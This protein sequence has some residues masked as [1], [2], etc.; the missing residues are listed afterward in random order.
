[1]FQERPG[2]AGPSVVRRHR[3]GI[4][5]VHGI[6][7]QKSAET[8]VGWGD[9]LVEVVTL[10]TKG[11][12]R[13]HLVNATTG[14]GPA[15]ATLKLVTGPRSEGW[16]LRECWWADTFPVPSY[17][18]LVSRSLKAIPWAIVLHVAGRYWQQSKKGFSLVASASAVAK[19]VLALPFGLLAMT[20]LALGLPFGA[21][22]IKKLRKALLA[23]QS[24]LTATV[25]DV[26]VFIDS[27][28]RAAI[29]RGRV[30]DELRRLDELCDET[31]VVAHSQ[32][33]AV[34]L[35]AL[36]G[37]AQDVTEEEP[38]W[39][40]RE[41]PM[42][43]ALVTFGA[44]INQLVGL[45][46]LREDFGRAMLALSSEVAAGITIAWML[47]DVFNGRVTVGEL[48]TTFGYTIMILALLGLLAWWCYSMFSS[49]WLKFLATLFLALLVTGLVG[50]L[51]VGAIVVS[52]VAPTL[53][54][55]SLVLMGLTFAMFLSEEM[56]RVA[57]NVV[58]RPPGLARWVDLWAS[59]DPVPNGATRVS[60][61]GDALVEH[62][63]WNR[64]SVVGDHTAYWGNADGFV[65]R[66]VR[67]CAR[68]A[69]SPWL[70][71]LPPDTKSI[72]DRAEW[73]VGFLRISRLLLA[74]WWALT[75]ALLLPRLG[76][77]DLWLPPVPLP[78]M[79]LRLFG[80]SDGVPDWLRLALLNAMVALVLLGASQ[81]IWSRWTN[82][83]QE[84][85][86]EGWW[87]EGRGGL[88][89]WARLVGLA[90]P[91]SLSVFVLRG[92]WMGAAVADSLGGDV[93]T[94]ISGVLLYGFYVV[95]VAAALALGLAL[96]MPPPALPFREEGGTS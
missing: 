59:H 74:L 62:P 43:T 38:L 14:N 49:N 25:G 7:R 24:L 2:S 92:F 89:G 41:G 33:A 17:R 58:R 75:T 30:A 8:L 18:E 73:R 80:W 31:V 36:G 94:V 88:G 82:S 34:A 69:R 32:G 66:V 78:D 42:P 12:T 60:P 21:L 37:L 76:E 39:P 51:Y 19:L 27:P 93:G 64:G 11:A 91:L 52:P 16:L 96:A 26:L 13:A 10:A 46:V 65:L 55:W 87:P 54:A 29:L 45:R 44:G 84:R 79:L 72:D 81:S 67:E 6:G 22:P 61:E 4:L 86:L 77:A 70:G 40:P 57:Q 35:D 23:L 47:S 9:R 48:V 53:F 68:V 15:S 20:I 3:L 90:I 56:E 83:E 5:F 85:Y 71:T 1:M 95:A 50:A 28:T 63:I